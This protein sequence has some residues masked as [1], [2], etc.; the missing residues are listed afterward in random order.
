MQTQL[1][2]VNDD[3]D[4]QVLA[5]LL[6]HNLQLGSTINISSGYMNFPKFIVDLLAASKQPTTVLTSAPQANSFFEGGF[7]KRYIPYFYRAYEQ[8]L[9]KAVPSTTIKE[10][11]KCKQWLMVGGWTFHTKGIWI[12]E[13]N[14]R[15]VV[16]V[17]G[18]SNFNMRSFE[19]DTECQ[20]YIYSECEALNERF[21]KEWGLLEKECKPITAK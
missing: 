19:R 7:F 16:S 13:P 9:L 11:V 6:R 1:N 21:K 3:S 10:Y 12:T 2:L 17:V 14:Q 5:E 18:S 8:Q 20:L 4:R 15:A